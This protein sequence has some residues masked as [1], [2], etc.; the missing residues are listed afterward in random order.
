MKGGFPCAKG[1]AW[2]PLKICETDWLAFRRVA[3]FFRKAG[4]I[5]ACK[6]PTRSGIYTYADACLNRLLHNSY[7][8]EMN[9]KNMRNLKPMN[10]SQDAQKK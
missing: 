6:W 7:R 10:L 5:L 2:M 3:Y 1:T 4:L 9:G 8:L